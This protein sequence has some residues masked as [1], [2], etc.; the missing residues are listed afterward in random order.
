MAEN[1]TLCAEGY[2]VG[3]TVTERDLTSLPQ[4]DS[5]LSQYVDYLLA[6]HAFDAPGFELISRQ[7]ITTLQGL[8]GETFL[9]STDT[10]LATGSGVVFMDEANG[11]AFDATYVASNEQLEWLDPLIAES[12][13]SFRSWAGVDRQA[14]PIHHLDQGNR[15][16]TG[17]NG[18][19]ARTAF[20][21]AIQLNPELT[22]AYAQRAY[23]HYLFEDL[24]SL[25]VDM[26]KAISLAPDDTALYL[27]K[28]DMLYRLYQY[29][30]AKAAMDDAIKIDG[31]DPALYTQ[32]AKVQAMLGDYDRALSDLN[33]ASTLAE[34]SLTWDAW[35]TLAFVHLRM[36][37]F[38]AAAMDYN[39]L[40]DYAD[41]PSP[42]ALMGA[43]IAHAELSENDIALD[44]LTD[45]MQAA[46]DLGAVRDPQLE[47][48]YE[49]AE[50][51][52][53]ELSE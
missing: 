3:L 5:E 48:L 52:H 14:D 23:I 34:G 20:T 6:Y 49:M 41:W 4:R 13:A 26:D 44:L 28:A 2:D 30:D 38:V 37:D 27:A 15:Y 11:V 10:G 46:Y 9:F 50:E 1:A 24:D 16:L 25:H 45:G 18:F 22:P 42:H 7:P 8:M 47:I 36:G 39:D 33:G 19:A 53:N 31:L 51:A 40:L 12:F 35:E 43:G 21:K 32:R 17:E 29:R